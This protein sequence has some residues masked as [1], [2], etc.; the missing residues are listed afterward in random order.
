[1]AG[2]PWSK[3]TIEKCM[4]RRELLYLIIGIP[5]PIIALLLIFYLSS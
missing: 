1:M 2:L 4:D 5:V 3:C